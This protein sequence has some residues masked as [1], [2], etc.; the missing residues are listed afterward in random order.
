MCAGAK[1]RASPHC[2]PLAPACNAHANAPQH[3][4]TLSLAHAPTPALVVALLRGQPLSPPPSTLE[5]ATT[6][7]AGAV[8]GM[9]GMAWCMALATM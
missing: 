4:R 9:D 2:M 7:S 8:N 5:L 3:C 6:E 1:V